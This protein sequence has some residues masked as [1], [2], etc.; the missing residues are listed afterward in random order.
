MDRFRVYSSGKLI[1]RR[2]LSAALRK[3]GIRRGGDF[4]RRRC[5]DDALGAS[6]TPYLWSEILRRKLFDATLA[7]EAAC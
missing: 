3:R 6:R 2:L 4:S 5:A 7:I 1:S